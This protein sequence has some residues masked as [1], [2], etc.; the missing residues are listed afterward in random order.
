VSSSCCENRLKEK[1]EM[2]LKNRLSFKRLSLILSFLLLTAIVFSD[3]YIG[4]ISDKKVFTN[5]G[6]VPDRRVGLVLGTAK[7]YNGRKNLFYEP[8]ISA[9]AEL[10]HAGKIRAIIVSGSGYNETKTM[11]ND[12]IRFGVPE[13]RIFSDYAGF[14]TLDSIVRAE[15]VFGQRDYTI[16]SQ[17]WHCERAMFI[18]DRYSHDSIAYT[19]DDVGGY[20]GVKLRIREIFARFKAVLDIYILNKQPR[21]LGPRVRVCT[22]SI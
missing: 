7:F 22:D 19:A 21:F 3:L 6:S 14:R 15:E 17:E 9:A 5:V 8:R 13:N 18:S 11:K 1:P 2:N 12:L 4:R 20:W 10:F 16:I